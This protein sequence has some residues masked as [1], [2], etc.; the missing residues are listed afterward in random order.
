MDKISV[1]GQ[2]NGEDSSV[3]SVSDDEK[4]SKLSI[5]DLAPSK[6]RR[7]EIVDVHFVKE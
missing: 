7:V 1:T 6:E 3:S 5:Y 4:N 2:A